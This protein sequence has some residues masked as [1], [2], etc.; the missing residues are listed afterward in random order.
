[1]K[2]LPVL[3]LSLLAAGGAASDVKPD[4]EIN[5]LLDRIVAREQAFLERMK[6]RAPLVE[7]YIQGIR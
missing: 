6:L 2:L 1:M 3:L 4:S 7:T 5:R